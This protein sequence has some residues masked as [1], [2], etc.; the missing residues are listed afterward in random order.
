MKYYTLYKKDRKLNFNSQDAGIGDGG[1]E[2]DPAQEISSAL[3][4][5]INVEM[6]KSSNNER[7]VEEV[8][9]KNFN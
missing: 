6:I 1:Q 4:I 3:M 5:R 7:M 9:L 8:W 2:Q